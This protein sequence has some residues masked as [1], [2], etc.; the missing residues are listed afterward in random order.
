MSTRFRMQTQFSPMNTNQH[1][2]D[3]TRGSGAWRFCM[4]FVIAVALFNGVAINAQDRPNILF[5]FTDDQ[6]QSCLGCIGNEHIQT[7]HLDR[8][9]AKGV[10]FTNAFVTTA[11]CCSNRVLVYFA[12]NRPAA[13]F[14]FVRALNGAYCRARQC[15]GSS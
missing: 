1:W 5:L 11:I 8:L 9:A 13:E 15:A 14:Q 12:R 10:L 2:L 3:A 6:P 7:P 4:F